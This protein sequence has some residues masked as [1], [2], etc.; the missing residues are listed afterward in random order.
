[1]RG[2]CADYGAEMDT[3]SLIASA[4]ATLSAVVGGVGGLF[5][6]EGTTHAATLTFDADATLPRRTQLLVPGRSLAAVARF[7]QP[8]PPTGFRTICLR[9]PDAY[10][11]DRPQDFLL[12]S[13]ADG[14]P[15]HHA[16]LPSPGIDDRLYSSLW[17]YL[18]GW[19]P[20]VFGLRAVT[21]ASPAAPTRGDDFHVLLSGAVGRFRRIGLLTLGDE[22]AAE[23]TAFDAGNTGGGLRALPPAR[24]YRG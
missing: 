8:G 18:A 3:A 12:A 22:T 6:G 21:V 15:F 17:L 5:D 20:V 23:T 4:G 19:E 11:P 14:V 9:L 2:R 7:S 16:V 24:L 1:M 10:G 13:S